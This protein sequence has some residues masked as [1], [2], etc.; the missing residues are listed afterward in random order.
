MDQTLACSLDGGESAIATSHASPVRQAA[1]DIVDLRRQTLA[2]MHEVFN[3]LWDGPAATAL[4]AKGDARN[5]KQRSAVSGIA[6][7]LAHDRVELTYL[8]I[9]IASVLLCGRG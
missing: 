1:R 8:W 4:A 6:M 7:D 3:L 2:V 9:N 5:E